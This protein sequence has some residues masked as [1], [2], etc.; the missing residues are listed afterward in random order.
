MALQ[1]DNK[2]K[3]LPLDKVAIA[4]S[5]LSE[6]DDAIRATASQA[7]GAIVGGYEENIDEDIRNY[8]SELAEGA[9]QGSKV[10]GSA[11]MD[12]INVIDK[13]RGFAAGVWDE[14]SPGAG[15]DVMDE[16]SFS[17]R[18]L[19]G[20]VE[21]WKD[22]S[23]KSFGDEFTSLYPKWFT[24]IPYLG[25]TAKFGTDITAN[26]MGDPLTYAP[27]AVVTVPYR[28]VKG[29]VNAVAGA[30]AAQPVLQ[31]KAVTGFLEAFNIYTGDAA[32]AQ[33]FLNILRLE[34]KGADI[35]AVRDSA[36]LL[37][38]LEQIAKAS[39]ETV[40]DIKKAILDAVEAGQ[41]STL[42]R[43]GDDA[44]KYA[45][46][47]VSYF[48]ALLESERAHGINV[49]DLMRVTGDDGKQIL[50]PGMGM[51]RA[52][53]LGVGGYLPHILQRGTIGYKVQSLLKRAMPFA[54]QRKIAGTIS[55]IN[56]KHGRKLFM[57]DPVALH[58]I[59]G[60]WSARATAA[61][62]M[63]NKAGDEFGVRVGR[64]VESTTP[65]GKPTHFDTAGNKIDEDWYVI[66]GSSHAMPAQMARVIQRQHALLS[67]P[68]EIKGLLKTY[69]N[70]QNWWKKYSLATRPAW[71]TRNAIGNIWN[72]YFIG[73]LT[74]ARL[75]GEAAA[76]QRAMKQGDDF[77]STY[78]GKRTAKVHVDPNAKVAGTDMTRQEIF[79]AAISKGVYESGLYGS[80]IGQ[81]ILSQSGKQ[82]NIIGATEWKGINKMF[83]AGKT[84]ENN[85]RLALFIDGIKKGKSLDDAAFNVRKSLFDY[86][87]LSD[88]EKRYMKRLFPFYTWTR[89]NIPAQFE[90]MVKHP[91]RANKI[92]IMI[93]A[94]QGDTSK[95]DESDIEDWVKG[96]FPIFLNAKE[97][98]DTYT[99]I[100]TMSYVPTAELNRLFQDPK[101]YADL[102]GG[103]LSPLLKLPIELMI[104][105]DTFRGKKIDAS[106]RGQGFGEFGEGFFDSY[107]GQNQE[108]TS[109]GGKKEKI[110]VGSESFLGINMTPK[111]KHL[112][113]AIVLLGE[114]DRL[115]PFSI[116]G[117][118]EGK[119]S[120][121]GTERRYH[122]IPE[123]SRWIR[124]ILGARVY[125]RKKGMGAYSKVRKLESDIDY[126]KRAVKKAAA[127]NNNPLLHHLLD[128]LDAVYAGAESLN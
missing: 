108:V 80:D 99:F 90:A 25:A 107:P 45:T 54:S 109:V 78:I 21:G 7:A 122:D 51:R 62:R 72:A 32:A 23:S 117:D 9:K 16:R 48:K 101:G 100:T 61:S 65:G 96:Q 97:S 82:S 118:D 83:A 67:S 14:L 41:I 19:E 102:T 6:M 39:G 98:E 75:Y 29:A 113:Q 84:L 33:K 18:L 63:L 37:Q 124:A 64:T 126:L 95:I 79:D 115:N 35:T 15:S 12:V 28:I 50:I 42:A 87:D 111:Q 49:A 74:D 53:E 68:K 44:I 116:F 123:S 77:L 85:A 20:G 128:Q 36:E 26:I 71:H 104:N 127:T 121:A 5:L 89:K 24:D 47:E 22:P 31:S 94:M 1:Q 52:M 106:Q 13:P 57:D 69:D 38:R 105:Y 91:D 76:I 43:Y 86:S 66:P 11:F 110:G 58:V 125:K 59:R 17:E 81:G 112:A 46:D 27:T 3:K 40:P 103:M 8:V 70:V 56:A 55:E 119:K 60:M 88:I 34:D 10:V 73:G 2:K 4:S 120:W 30:K 93:D 92:N 114:V